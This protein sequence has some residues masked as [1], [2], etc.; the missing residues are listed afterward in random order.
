MTWP[1]PHEGIYGT[2]RTDND[3]LD[4]GH[5]ARPHRDALYAMGQLLRRAVL[6]GDQAPIAAALCARIATPHPGDLVIETSQ[7][8]RNPSDQLRAFGILLAY[9]IEWAESNEEWDAYLAARTGPAPDRQHIDAWYIQYGPAPADVARWANADFAA[10][11]I[12]V[13]SRWLEAEAQKY[14]PTWQARQRTPQ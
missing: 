12:H 10:L 13:T 6:I 1:Q 14:L 8:P 4:L 2:D 5:P 9:R 11:P 7:H 3:L